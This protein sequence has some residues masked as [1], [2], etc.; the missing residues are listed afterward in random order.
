MRQVSIIILLVCVIVTGNIL[1]AFSAVNGRIEYSVPILYNNLDEKELVQKANFY[2]ANAEIL[3]NGM[4]NENMT[5][6]LMLYNLLQ[7]INP[8]NPEYSAKLGALQGK[9]GKDDMARK[10]FTKAIKIDSKN[11]VT[12][13]YLGEYYYDRDFYFRA[14]KCYNETYK[15][16]KNDYYLLYKMGDLY[17]KFGDTRSALKYLN[18]AKQQCSTPELE[19]KIKRIE[20]QNT[21]NNVYY[22][23]TRIRG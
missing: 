12:N 20:A 10:N 11:P 1:P 3:N 19:A 6:A 7:K 13:F 18:E 15:H 4:I 14:I 8:A 2:F 17:E 21:V 22:S 9:I 16:N 23:D 5:N